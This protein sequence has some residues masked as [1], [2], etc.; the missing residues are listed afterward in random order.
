MQRVKCI[1]LGILAIS[2]PAHLEQLCI[3]IVWWSMLNGLLFSSFIMV[4]F[5]G[6]TI[7]TVVPPQQTNP[8]QSVGVKQYLQQRK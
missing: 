5:P 4:S 2:L 1:T 6:E 8:S 7:K 3:A